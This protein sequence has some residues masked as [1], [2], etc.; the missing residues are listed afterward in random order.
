MIFSLSKLTHQEI[1]RSKLDAT[2][3]YEDKLFETIER[4]SHHLEKFNLHYLTKLEDKFLNIMQT[5]NTLD[6]NIKLLQVDCYGL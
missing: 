2:Q 5:M 6:T 4:I 3:S 1:I